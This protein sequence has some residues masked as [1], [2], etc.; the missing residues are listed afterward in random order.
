MSK[1]S[2]EDMSIVLDKWYQTK[3]EIAELEKKLDKYKK[4]ADKYFDYNDID[5]ISDSYFILKKREITKHTVSKKE[6]PIDIWNKYSKES[7]YTSYYLV[8]KKSL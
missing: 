7:T 8:P 3:Q 2:K 5:T 6:L 1:I 4:I